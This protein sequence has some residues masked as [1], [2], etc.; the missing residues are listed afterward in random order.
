MRLELA[1]SLTEPVKRQQHARPRQNG[2]RS[3]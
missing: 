1:G 3:V 2:A